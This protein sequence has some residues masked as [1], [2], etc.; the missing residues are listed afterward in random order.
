M[1]ASLGTGECIMLDRHNRIAPLQWDLMTQWIKE[2]LSTDAGEDSE[3]LGGFGPPISVP[4][5]VS[6]NGAHSTTEKGQEGLP[7]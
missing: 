4:A 1:Q 5:G 2:A 3:A 6:V 7:S